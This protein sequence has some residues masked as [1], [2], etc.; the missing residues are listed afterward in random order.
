MLKTSRVPNR[1]SPERLGPGHSRLLLKGAKRVFLWELQKAVGRVTNEEI[2]AAGALR[3]ETAHAQARRPNKRKGWEKRLK[4]YGVI[5]KILTANPTLQG[6]D[7]C[8]DLDRRHAQPLHDWVASG[9]WRTGL[10]W[11]EAWREPELRRKI[12][13]VRQ[14]AQKKS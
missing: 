14:E 5:R 13:R 8:A 4:L 11:K 6:I 9:E 2:A 1:E 10:T 7:F 12:R 3:T